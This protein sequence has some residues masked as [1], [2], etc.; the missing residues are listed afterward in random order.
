MFPAEGTEAVFADNFILRANVEVR[1]EI[2][3]FERFPR[4]RAALPGRPSDLTAIVAGYR[5]RTGLISVP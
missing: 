1:P 5:P 3:A 4:R 2:V